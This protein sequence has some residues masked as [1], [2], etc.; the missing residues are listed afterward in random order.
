MGDHNRLK[1]EW[2]FSTFSK[3]LRN[4]YLKEFYDFLNY[5]EININFFT[6]FELYCLK[7]DIHNPYT[8]KMFLDTN[9]RMT[10]QWKTTN[11]EIII[12]THPHLE[13]IM[14]KVENIE[15]EAAPF[16]TIKNPDQATAITTR[17]DF[18][19]IHTQLNYTNQT[20][21]TIAEQLS[22]IEGAFPTPKEE[23]TTKL[24]PKRP[25]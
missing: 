5:H 23:I 17:K 4:H 6:W 19:H 11:K 16:K 12:S 7:Y 10:T 20:L 3:E 25:I 18:Y 22:R 21:N 2:Y 1:R 15:L 8:D 24:D 9:T 13:P 14:L